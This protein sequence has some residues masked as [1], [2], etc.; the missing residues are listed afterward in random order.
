[1]VPLVD[2]LVVLM[3]DQQVVL[4]VVLMVVPLVDQQVVL[5]VDMLVVQLVELELHNNCVRGLQLGIQQSRMFGKEF[6]N[7]ENLRQCNM[8]VHLCNHN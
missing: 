2:P 1:M 8:L 6:H 3:V 5:M 4:Q 7:L